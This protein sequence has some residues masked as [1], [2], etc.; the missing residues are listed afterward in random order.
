MSNA[1]TQGYISSGFRPTDGNLESYVVSIRTRKP[2]AYFGD[3]HFCSGV[4]ITSRIILTSAHCVMDG[5]RIITRPRR[6]RVVAGSPN[7]L[8]KERTTLEFMVFKVIPHPK[9]QRMKGYDIALL[10]LSDAIPR[11]N[12][13]IKIISLTKS[14]PTEGTHCQTLGWGQLFWDGPYADRITYANLSIVS[15]TLCRQA[16]GVHYTKDLICAANPKDSSVG[17]CRGDSGAPLIC[18]GKLVG[19]V[20]FSSMCNNLQPSTFTDVTYYSNWIITMGLGTKINGG[21]TCF[22]VLLILYLL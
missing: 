13:R 2:T 6:L 20:S 5:H 22:L 9:F 21:V 16:Y 11:W 18:H 17:T 3:N 14:R 19:I 4:I 8:K 1:D 15:D 10:V 7:R 12:T